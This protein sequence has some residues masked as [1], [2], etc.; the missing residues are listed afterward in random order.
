MAPSAHRRTLLA[1]RHL[2]VTLGNDLAVELVESSMTLPLLW[3][4][5]L[6]MTRRGVG[7]N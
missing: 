2:L 7:S 6:W 3:A 5:L 4:L 1:P